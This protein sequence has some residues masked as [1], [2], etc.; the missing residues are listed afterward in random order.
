[1][2]EYLQKIRREGITTK[3]GAILYLQKD[4]KISHEEAKKIV[5]DWN[6][7]FAFTD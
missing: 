7:K 3:V 2:D 6:R 1:M 4:F 5:E